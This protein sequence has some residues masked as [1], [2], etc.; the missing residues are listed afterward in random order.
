MKTVDR[1]IN[2]RGTLLCHLDTPTDV[3][4]SA[5]SEAPF[6]YPDDFPI[7]LFMEFTAANTVTW[8]FK[9]RND[10]P[11]DIIFILQTDVDVSLGYFL[12]ICFSRPILVIFIKFV[13]I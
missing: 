12:N 1:G 7:V 6:V 8:S 3:T 4:H 2:V 9:C 10:F 13:L 11:S 5:A